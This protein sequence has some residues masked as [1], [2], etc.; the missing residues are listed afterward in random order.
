MRNKIYLILIV[1][2]F[3]GTRLYKIGSIPGSVY[4]DEASIG[5]NAYSI[6]TDLK[7]EWGQTLPLHFR[8]FGE[9]KLPVYI[10]SVVPFVKVI[11]LNALAVRIPAV[12]Y[13]LGNI[14]LIYFLVKKITENE[15]IG[16]WSAFIFSISPWMFIFSRTGYEANAGIFFFFLATYLIIFSE[17]QKAKVILGVLSFIASFYSYNSFRIIIPIWMLIVFIY[18]FHKIS[19][20]K[21][22]W[23][24][25]A[26]SIIIFILSLIPVYRLYRFDTGGARISQVKSES[27]KEILNNYFANFSPNFLFTSGDKNPRS[28]IPGQGQLYF[29]EFPLIIMGIIFVLKSKKILYLIPLLLLLLA[30]IPAAITKESPH[31]LRAILAAPSFAILSA[32]GINFFAGLF[33]KNSEMI[34]VAMALFYILFFG[35]Y[36]VKF[37]D[38]YQLDT[39]SS[40][41]YEYK[42]IFANQKE[43]LVTDKYAQPYIFALFYEKYSPEKF[44]KEVTYNPPD[45]WGVSLV[46]SFNGYIFK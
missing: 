34:F 1:L 23:M 33:K 10:Y 15:S 5:Y 7:D 31:A 45:R 4:W 44:R 25:V 13:G 36:F 16:L 19:S 11:G 42:E 32:F 14:F 26:A 2:L 41:Q 18:K 40:W 38:D 37:I 29:I 17:K 22:Y 39:S 8:A 27:K 6:G 9:F 28:Q 21:K 35:E 20:I 3:L 30:P 43:G 12:L 46:S 24:Y